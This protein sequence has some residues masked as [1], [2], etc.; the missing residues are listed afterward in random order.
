MPR[1]RLIDLEPA[2]LAL[3]EIRYWV[4][5]QRAVVVGVQRVVVQTG[6]LSGS[7]LMMQSCD[8]MGRSSDTSV[9]ER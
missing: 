4:V 6:S 8:G 2:V 1:Q 5:L 7:T 3:D 9:A